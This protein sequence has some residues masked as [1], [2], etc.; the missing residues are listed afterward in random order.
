MSV[1]YTLLLVVALASSVSA[2]GPRRQSRRHAH[3][4][5]RHTR[6]E[7]LN[8]GNV[9]IFVHG[10]TFP[11]I[12]RLMLHNPKRRGMYRYTF[13]LTTGRERLA[14]VLH[15][16]DAKQ[17]PAESFYKF[18]WS[19]HLGFDERKEAAESLLSYL[20]NHKGTITLI[21]HSHGCNVALYLAT[22]AKA[23]LAKAELA[24][25]N[26]SVSIDRLVLLAPPVQRATKELVHS[27]LF[28]KVYSFYSSGDLIQIADP[29]GMYTETKKNG[30]ESSF[31]SKRT[32]TKAPNLVQA[33]VLYDRQSPGHNAFIMPRFFK[34]IPQL[35]EVLNAAHTK[36]K[37]HIVVTIPRYPTMPHLLTS[38]EIAQGYVP[39]R[40]RSC[41]CNEEG[42]FF[43]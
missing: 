12:S 39:R 42:R 25:N 14:K 29:Q 32:Y 30:T 9:T 8:E 7:K 15:D 18:Y 17:F 34:R 20:K 1:R 21:A 22:L 23:T 38:A 43:A 13:G 16:A 5:I 24:K 27:S 35:L 11:G 28:K 10:T 41:T 40:V 3:K 26:P 37:D 2:Q 31:F 4:Y 33:R 36:G 19:G 6:C